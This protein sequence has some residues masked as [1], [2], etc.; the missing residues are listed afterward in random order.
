LSGALSELIFYSIDSF[1][2]QLQAGEKIKVSHLFRG[3]IPIACCGSL[4]SF[5]VFFG[6][7]YQCKQY[8]CENGYTTHGVLGSSILAAVPSSIIAV[9][10]D[11]MKKR[12]ILGYENSIR[13]AA[14]VSYRTYGIKGFFLG[15]QV[16]L[17]RDIPFAGLKISL[18][19]GISYA[20]LEYYKHKVDPFSD[21]LLTPIESAL[22]GLICGPITAVITSPL[23]CVNTRIKSGELASFNFLRA[24]VEVVKRSGFIG[25][26]RGL[27][28]RTAILSCGSTVFWFWYSQ[29]QRILGSEEA[30][31]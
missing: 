27:V 23:D 5:G 13:E 6:V 17:L 7:F 14:L 15:W 18:Y 22:V 1:K 31:S 12:I 30:M 4:P 25:L 19:E 10:A 3:A 8:F 28:P 29:F 20:Y 9:P 26:F 24:H 16:N 2:V 21:N 11:V